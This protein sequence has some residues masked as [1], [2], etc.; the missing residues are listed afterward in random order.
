MALTY[1]WSR[2]PLAFPDSCRTRSGTV[3][4]PPVFSALARTTTSSMPTARNTTPCLAC[5]LPGWLCVFTHAPRLVTRTPLHLIVHVHERGRTS[6]TARL[7]TLAARDT[8]LV[9]HGGLPAPPDP[10]V[11]VPAGAT[12]LFLSPAG[13]ARTLTTELVAALPTPPALV[14]PD[15]NWKQAGRMVKRQPLLAAATKVSLLARTF[16]GHALRCNRPGHRMSTYEA[17]VQA[18]AVP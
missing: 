3:R 17:V 14:V 2:V 13:G 1:R 16:T 9:G 18:L 10:A 7:L 8:T 6:N 12:P 11:H 15:G 5:R 4:A